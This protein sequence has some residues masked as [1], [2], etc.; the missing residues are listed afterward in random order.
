M[1]DPVVTDI[2]KKHNKTTAQVLL[3]NMVQ[4]GIAVIPK[5]STPSRIKENIQVNI[6]VIPKSSTP[7]RMKENMQVNIASVIALLKTLGR[8]QHFGG[9]HRT[10]SMAT[11][12]LQEQS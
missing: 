10:P 8:F 3:R 2:S 1:S 12:V 5:S 4:R 11:V 6:A 7:S 9:G